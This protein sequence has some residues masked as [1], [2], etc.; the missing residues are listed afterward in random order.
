MTV[1]SVDTSAAV[2]ASL[3]DDQGNELATQTV[4]EQRRHAE[5][6]APLIE[7]LMRETGTSSTDITTVVGGTGP[8]PFTG[9]R[10][11]LV[12]ARTFAFGV[13]KEALGVSSL[14][15]LAAQAAAE[16]ELQA[17]DK[18]LVV[19]DARRREVYYALYE[20]GA[21]TAYGAIAVQ[22]L[23]GPEVSSATELVERGLAEHAIVV[24]E[25]AALYRDA[26]T[27]YD[28]RESP[29]IPSATVLAQLA[30][31]RQADGQELP[32]TPLYLRRPDAQVPAARKRAL[33]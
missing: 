9:L 1:L 6:L 23:E 8:A 26:F 4:R 21:A 20:V 29:A 3:L 12:T 7:Q 25:G 2:S 30:L 28:V 24:G 19:A 22:A 33:P 18:V 5:Q 10:V 11:G 32:T 31:A 13:G 15:A 17:G 27:G 14:D 16:H